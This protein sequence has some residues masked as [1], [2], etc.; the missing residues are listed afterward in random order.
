MLWYILIIYLA[1]GVIVTGPLTYIGALIEQPEIT[2][3]DLRDLKFWIGHGLGSLLAVIVWPYWIG[4][5]I[6]YAYS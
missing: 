2:R 5:I 4:R 3:E 6:Y 1:I